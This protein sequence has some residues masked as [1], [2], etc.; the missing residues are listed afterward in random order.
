MIR[1]NLRDNRSQGGE[2]TAVQFSDIHGRDVSRA[3]VRHH[4][5]VVVA[6]INEWLWPAGPRQP[7]LAGCG[8]S[9]YQSKP[10][11]QRR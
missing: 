10:A 6:A 5:T 11:F 9:E 2:G 1:A 3:A 8:S 4:A 7:L